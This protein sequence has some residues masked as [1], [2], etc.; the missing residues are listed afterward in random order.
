MKK[1]LRLFLL[2]LCLMTSGAF[3][4]KAETPSASD[5]MIEVAIL[6]PQVDQYA[7]FEA[8]IDFIANFSNPYDYDQI[9]VR[10]TFIAPDA[11]E[12]TVDGFYMQDYTL[13]TSS[14]N[15]STLGTGEFRVR[16][17]PDQ[18]GTWQFRVSV[19]DSN[20][21]LESDLLTFVCTANSNAG[22]N[23]GFLRSNNS[24]YLHFDD[25]SP[26]IAI[27]QNIAWPNNNPYLNYS[28][29]LEGMI[30]NGAN[31]FR[32]WH[33]HWGLGIEWRQGDGFEGLRRYKQSNCYYQDWL[34]DYCAENGL[35]I[36]LALQHHG[37]V[38]TQ[39][40]PNWGE[41]P[42]NASNGG[43]CQNTVD[44]FTNEE[45]K[46]H[47]KNRYRYILARW[48]YAR[49]ILCWEL[50]N[51]VHWT[52][53]FEANKDMVADW[54]F[55]M[56]EY[57]KTKDPYS[58]LVSS[59][60]GANTTDENVWSHPAIDFTQSHIYI[61]TPNME[62][63]LAQAN[64]N[65]LD[66]FGKPTLNGEFGLGGSSTLANEDPDG[67]H[68]H[69][70]LW[71]GLFSGA[72]GT[73]MT[74]W[75]D[76]YIHPQNLYHHFSG[77]AQFVADLPFYNSFF[78]P[79]VNAAV[80]GAPGNLVLTPSLGWGYVGLSNINIADNVMVSPPGAALG[81][82]LYGSQWNTQYRSPPTFAVTYPE[83]GIFSV[84]T[85][86]ETGTSPKIA[87]WL[88]GSLLLEQDAVPNSVYSIN[89]P[90]GNHSIKVDN[91]G[92]DW[93]TIAAY[94]FEGLGSRVDAYVLVSEDKSKA[95]GWATNTDYNHLNVYEN[96]LPEPTPSSSIRL[97]G[98]Q[99]GVYSVRWFNPLT[100]VP[101]GSN[102]A[103]A[104]NNVL[105]IPLPVLTW[106][107]AFVV[108]DT[109]TTTI[110]QERHLTFEL[111]PVP[112]QAGTVIRIGLPG[113][114]EG[115]RL[116]AL[117]DSS[118]KPIHQYA[119]TTQESMDLP[120]GLPP[121]LYWVKVSFDGRIGVKPL[122]VTRF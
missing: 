6:S 39:V 54:H 21:T 73:A 81:Q 87:I 37:P 82:F 64:R 46:A 22:H 71:G 31:F 59:S 105:S 115:L 19:T 17:A 95:A 11:Q 121:G 108:D 15:L 85:S 90:S 70:S 47:T 112:A 98:F 114:P 110:Q 50:F 29:W 48:G 86:A 62:R 5:Q 14:G 12:K 72:L 75:W 106:D 93:I 56:A 1:A 25:G 58:H 24:N 92:T 80:V 43:P 35:Y 27:G 66:Q 52:D 36:M 100:Y 94:T 7:K 89:V 88:D 120:Q 83:A 4:A 2:P 60:Y 103:V 69:N 51:E 18:P 10:A 122:V 67:I 61:N 23:H 102:T 38:S 79:A 20:G 107:V 76:S 3:T 97:E 101:Y 26:Y 74:W 63:V 44:F 91:T 41:S 49:S 40:N 118:G 65:F 34:F 13:N 53:N 111:F 117:L 68:I 45:A 116:V 32:L 78:T 42:Y 8:R 28:T 77:L 99:D 9:S 119:A 104:S 96:G 109:P 84:K 30:E 113:Q 16:F 55:E 33:A 57:L